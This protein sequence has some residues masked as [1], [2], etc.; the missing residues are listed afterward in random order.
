LTLPAN[1]YIQQVEVVVGGNLPRAGFVQPVE[2]AGGGGGIVTG[3][4]AAGQVTFWTGAQTVSGSSSFFWDN[5][6]TTLNRT[7]SIT[8]DSGATYFEKY[9]TSDPDALPFWFSAGSSTCPLGTRNDVCFTWG[10]NMNLRGKVSS[11]DCSYGIQLETYWYA[12][13][14]TENVEY[15]LDYNNAAGTATR[16][17]FQFRVSRVADYTSGLFGCDIIDYYTADYNTLYARMTDNA[18]RLGPSA[19]LQWTGVSDFSGTAYD[20]QLVRGGAGVLRQQNADV[21]GGQDFQVWGATTGSKYLSMLHNG[22][23]A[24]VKVYGGGDMTLATNSNNLYLSNSF[25]TIGHVGAIFAGT[26]DNTLAIGSAALRWTSVNSV[27]FRVYT[28]VSDANASASLSAGTLSLGA[29]GGTAL[30]CILVRD[31][32][33]VIAQK[34]STTAQEFRVYGTTTS[35]KYSNL[36]HDGTNGSISS[37]SGNFTI[38]AASTTVTLANNFASVAFIS[39]AWQAGAGADNLIDLGV[40]STKRWRHL[41]YTGNLQMEAVS[42]GGLY[43]VQQATELLTIAAAATT[44]TALSVP[45]NAVILGCSVRVTTV[46]PTATTFTVTTAAG[47]T[48]LSTAAVSTA[49][50]STDPGTKAGPFFQSA[51]TNIRITPNLTPGAATGVV[52]VTVY[53][54]T[55]TPP[56]S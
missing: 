32:A 53:Y 44:D 41:Y 37:S 22:T 42:N 17:P 1:G 33:N 2:N 51:A 48:T 27:L 13:A 56:T 38:T 45:A 36:K 20:L 10:Y 7:N 6:N 26:V 18:F 14:T 40:T 31:T 12:D 4:G 35:S 54:Y 3:S 47:G 39:G 30:D 49:A 15:H 46:I 50:N 34:N 11:A 55:V 52:R 25:A 43:A 16:R 24:I 19:A 9:L 28:S 8:N 29:G 23:N 5:A 21:A